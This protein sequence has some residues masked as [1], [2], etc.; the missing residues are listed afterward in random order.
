MPPKK[1]PENAKKVFEDH[2]E[3]M[4]TLV[5]C[6]EDTANGSKPSQTVVNEIK[7]AYDKANGS[8]MNLKGVDPDY[9]TT[10]PE[11][12]E[13]KKKISKEYMKFLQKCKR[14]SESSGDE[15]SESPEL[16][17]AQSLVAEM[18]V[19]ENLIEGAQ[20]RLQKVYSETPDPNDMSVSLANKAYE[21]IK[22]MESEAR[23]VFVKLEVLINTKT[24]LE[25][26]KEEV[27]KKW[28]EMSTGVA[29]K[30]SE[31]EAYL[32]KYGPYEAI[33]EKKTVTS[34]SFQQGNL[35][36]MPKNILERLPLPTFDGQKMNFLR[37]KK[38]FSNHVTYSTEKER[39][40]A[41]KTKCLLKPADKNRVMN[42]QTLQD[43][44]D[45]LEEEY[46]DINTLVA[47]IFQ[48][49]QSLKN[50]RNDQEF[51]K[52]VTAIEN[53]VSCL[54]SL[55]HEKEMEFSFMAVTLEN[56]LDERM[57]KEFSVDY[58]KDEN[59]DKER[60]KSLLKYLIQQK[61]AAHLRTCNYGKDKR[62]ED[63]PSTKS[64][65][66]MH[67]P[68]GDRGGRGGHGRGK[69]HGERG[70]GQHGGPY[71]SDAEF[72]GGRGFRGK[73]VG[74]RQ[75]GRGGN[76]KRGEALKTC[77]VCAKDHPTSKCDTWRSTS[78]SK[79]ELFA[80]AFNLSQKICTWCLDPGHLSYNCLVEDPVGCPCGS[81]FSMYICVK[82]P[83]CKSRKNW[84]TGNAV[85]S[86]AG[87][88]HQPAG[89]IS[90]NGVPMG[91]ALL[92]VQNV[93]TSAGYQLRT[94][95]DNCSQSTFLSEATA[96]KRKMH[97]IPIKYTLVCTDGR[98]EPKTGRL[99]NLVLVDSGGKFIHI[100]AVGI[101][102]L[103]GKFSA[104]KVTG[105]EN[106]FSEHD[107]FD[108]DLERSEGDLDLL[109]GTDLM[110]LHPV[111]AGNHG[112]LVLLKSRFG[113]RFTLAGYDPEIIESDGDILDRSKVNNV[114]TKD[115]QVFDLL[116]IESVGVD[117][118]K[119]CNNCNSCKD[120]KF[121]AQ[122]MTYLE[123][124]EDEI[125]KKDI[126]FLPEEKRYIV[127]YPYTKEIYNL[128]PN[129]EIAKTRAFQLEEILK[130]SPKDL[131][132]ANLILA[133][134]FKRNVFRYLTSHEMQSW[135]GPVHYVPL[136][137]VYKE[138]E[139]TPCRLTFDSSQPDKNGLSL[140]GCMG[141]GRNPLNYF[142]GVVLNWRAAE[143]VACGDISKMFNQCMVRDFDMHVRRFFVRPDG[144]GGKEPFR[145]AVVAV[146]N[147]G[148]KAAGSIA[149]A[150][151]DKIAKDNEHISPDV[152]KMLIDNCFMDDVNV[153]AKYGENLDDNIK[154]AEAIMEQG[155]WK[156]KE[157]TKCGDP[158]EKQ[159][160]KEVSKALG[161]YWKTGSDEIVYKTRI[162]F[163]K[164]YRNR[165][166]QP[167]S[168][169]ET[170][171]TDFPEK[172]TKRIA[173]KIIHSVFDPAMLIQP[174]ILKLRLA[175]REIIVQEKLN[176]ESGWDKVL[177]DSVRKKWVELSKEMYELE[178]ISFD[179]SLVP[180][181]YDE[182][183]MPRL[184]IFSDYSASGLCVVTYLLWI[185]KDGSTQ[186]R[187]VTSR[188]KIASLKNVTT[189]HGELLAGQ[190]GSRLKTW[191]LD[192]LDLKV[193]KVI[194]MVDSSIVLGMIK[195]VSL[196]FDTFTAPRVAEI[197]ANMGDTSWYWV[198][199][200]N[201]PSDLGTRGNVSPKDLDKGSMW[202]NGPDWLT[203]K[204]EQW[205]I[206]ED[207][208]K[209]DIPG[210]KKE[211]EVLS[212]FSTLTELAAL[213]E[214]VLPSNIQTTHASATKIDE[215][216]TDITKKFVDVFDAKK[217]SSWFLLQKIVARI[218]QWK[219]A[220]KWKENA[221]E[222][223]TRARRVLLMQM[224][225]MTREMI[226]KRKLST[227]LLHTACDGLVYVVSRAQNNSYNQDKLVLL[228]PEHPYT[229]LILKSFHDINH[230]GV[231]HTV[232]R[233][234]LWYWIPQAAKIVRSI[235]NS[236]HTCRL[237]EAKALQQMMSPIP[238]LRLKPTPAWHFSMIDLA[239]PVFVKGFV[240]QRTTRKT[241]MVII[242]CLA[243]R[244]V[245]CYLAEDYSTDSLLLV[246][247]KHEAR[248]GSPAV[249]FA[250][251]GSQIK[252]ADNALSE[253]AEN[254]AK[255][256]ESRLQEYGLKNEIKFKFGVPH[257]PEGQGAVE[258]LIAE[259]K[260]ELKFITK[261]RLFTFAQLDA[262]L[263][264]CAYLVNCRPLQLSPG[265]GGEDGYICPN[266]LMMGRSDKKPALGPFEVSK[267]TK[268]VAFMRSVVEQFWDRW[269]T[270]YLQRL[271]QYQKWRSV[272]RNVK[273]G[274][275]VLILDREAPKGSFTLGEIVKV[276]TDEDNIVRKVTLR[277]KIKNAGK[278]ED[279][280]PAA[281]KYVDRN[282]RGLAL[283]ITA[284]ERNDVE[285]KLSE[286]QNPGEEHDDH[287]I[288][289]KMEVKNPEAGGEV[290]IDVKKTIFDNNNE[291]EIRICDDDNSVDL[292]EN[293]G[294]EVDVA[295]EEDRAGDGETSLPPTSSGR[296]RRKPQRYGNY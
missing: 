191:L 257:F 282:V 289:A 50:P 204:F 146:V 211:F 1:D 286:V 135:T 148:E 160:G 117:I 66:A 141:K 105:I 85:K 9:K 6:F 237:L 54:K 64:G 264:E 24:G 202:Q 132:S 106:I 291:E 263:A 209:H 156:F 42:E 11:V 14:S 87:F 32:A 69:R 254:V 275:V 200:Q 172:F 68:G 180:K 126:E 46:G 198:D 41:L 29:K 72:Q 175:Y 8:Y 45:R 71:E 98:E 171:E 83:D 231:N 84:N 245:Q 241:W 173:L 267:L 121:S 197:Q 116:S 19:F 128:L 12:D 262:V 40:L 196:K 283:V 125:I 113:S 107:V 222:L 242:T 100:Q 210:M 63:D 255:L 130:K 185:M 108:N 151:K 16:K 243:S 189:P 102:K 215:E 67:G 70:R 268:K 253:I 266:D 227:L 36:P 179:R 80:T 271:S 97:G 270:S 192:T 273:P 158:G 226:K 195:N 44:W 203:M 246:L 112:K 252:G 114:Q 187:I 136:N 163:G 145:V 277:Y 206:R 188:V 120:C 225:P 95:F 56:K 287:I 223:M 259:V 38:E 174:F 159:I 168:T 169:S 35:Q 104:V 258:R 48:N 10:F 285:N 138:S 153:K 4:L 164:K 284:E 244:A 53:G 236:C 2:A 143:Q 79:E 127:S 272:K 78:T 43:C 183:E 119:K 61:K 59:E 235:K 251:L 28:T 77:L 281:D 75:R 261:S 230:R 47:E 22:L 193:G 3:E 290:D 194:H 39:M 152:S 224:M 228:S 96:R 178:M 91:K 89:I 25:N 124:L 58:T 74:Y 23:K 248:N 217:H 62:V 49:W 201:N 13:T 55:G 176:N 111:Y 218:Y 99:Y 18:D 51:I 238:A 15:E 157:W 140:N 115:I 31:A 131:E 293:G 219:T 147:F 205:P 33:E 123:A 101:D 177:P 65:S 133:D 292:K 94:M 154:K 184:L 182:E 260:K 30:L 208:R 199:T 239:G 110:E 165:R 93:D 149:T 144:F 269:S 216:D 60:M 129:E 90:P 294:Q 26:K 232:A 280:V 240:N 186:V 7:V 161:V 167:F 233:S 278:G 82:T 92:P 220:V 21:D 190:V 88:V 134:S 139:S 20:V 279:Y 103:S 213:Q 234:R 214:H 17:A 229:R 27:N 247:A 155:G 162:N 250:D 81:N 73:G 137:R 276:K 249:Y 256:D 296:R 265:P 118:P 170:I 288:D 295:D 34:P 181:D 150:V 212:H 57:K 221:Q 207:F 274:D 122:R 5:E 86:G 166:D 52:F 142:G 37:F 109:M 76:Q